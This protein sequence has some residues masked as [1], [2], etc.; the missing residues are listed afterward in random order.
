MLKVM[1]NCNPHAEL[2]LNNYREDLNLYNKLLSQ[3]RTLGRNVES[4][5]SIMQTELSLQWKERQKWFAELQQRDKENATFRERVCV[6]LG[7]DEFKLELLEGKVP[8]DVYQSF[9]QVIG[10][11][12]ETIN[13]LMVADRELVI[14]LNMEVEATKLELHRVQGSKRMRN[15]YGAGQEPEARFVDKMR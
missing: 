1:L 10:L 8:E 11:L 6:E 13:E 15:A 14:T 4:H 12:K 2:L 9:S 7:M 3:A 5:G